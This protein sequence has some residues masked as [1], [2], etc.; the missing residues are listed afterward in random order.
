[1]NLLRNNLTGHLK[2]KYQVSF[3]WRRD[4]QLFVKKSIMLEYYQSLTHVSTE[5]I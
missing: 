4:Q 5:P 1:M 3:K 2:T